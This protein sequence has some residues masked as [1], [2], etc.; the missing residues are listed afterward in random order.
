MLKRTFDILTSLLGLLL[1][2]PIFVVIAVAVKLDSRGPI[3]YRGVRAGMNGVPFRIFK[4]RTMVPNAEQIGGYST[5]KRDPRITRIGSFL[6]RHKLDELPQFLN[7]LRGEM[8]IVGPRPE[9]VEYTDL[10]SGD[11][12]LILTVRPGI[13]DYS[14]LKFVHLEDALGEKNPDLVYE[15]RVRPVKNMLRI[16][17]VKTQS[18][19]ADLVII[20]RTL[21][22]LIGVPL[23]NTRS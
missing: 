4:F 2:S 7:V 20:L 22:K 13:T 3:L 14:S 5:G 9:I 16:Q 21:L 18:F 17:Y 10:Y 15:Q 19:H 6:R 12:K 23:C 1:L 11:E 8:S